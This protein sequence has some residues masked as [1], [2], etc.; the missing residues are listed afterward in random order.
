LRT[1]KK[2]ELAKFHRNNIIAAAECLFSEKGLERTTMDDIA[3]KA[4]YSKATIYVYFKNKDEIFSMIVYNSMKLL[5]DQIG[6]AITVGADFYEKYS[7]ICNE[8][9][10]YREEYPLY[11]ESTIGEINVDL[12][13]DET[14]QV[15]RDIFLVGE[16]INEEIAVFLQD[17]L[18]QGIVR[19]DIEMLQTVHFFW[20]CIVGLIRMAGQ[21]QKYI[22]KAMGI[23][24]NEFLQNGFATLL[25]SILT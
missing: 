22:E 21:K 9:V 15:F 8:L 14:P 7:G 18:N 17:G 25:R 13:A 3:K 4:D 20:S 23:T 10:R 5:R 1:D 11:F 6:N 19:E 16:E 24:K 12:E 2:T